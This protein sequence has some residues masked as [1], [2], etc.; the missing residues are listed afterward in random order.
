MEIGRSHHKSHHSGRWRFWRMMVKALA[1]LA[2]SVRRRG[3]DGRLANRR[4]QPLGHISVAVHMP[5]R[6]RTGKGML[7]RMSGS[8]LGRVKMILDYPGSG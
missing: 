2:I 5:E 8:G 6:H 3:L 1:G 4:L 7:G